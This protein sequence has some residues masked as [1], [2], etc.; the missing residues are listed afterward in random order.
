MDDALA[1]KQG[2][3]LPLFRLSRM[4]RSAALVSIPVSRSPVRNTRTPRS[5][6]R[7]A[8]A[9]RACSSTQGRFEPGSCSM[10]GA[11]PQ[12]AARNR[13]TER[14]F[15][16]S[17]REKSF[18]EISQ[19]RFGRSGPRRSRD[20]HDAHREQYVRKPP[21]LSGRDDEHG[22]RRHHLGIEILFH[23]PGYH[24]GARELW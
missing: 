9:R 21:G 11:T 23:T 5:F 6:W 7:G 12:A 15:G 17:D 14:S 20:G 3:D 2:T 22:I 18:I 19:N 8:A 1:L 24:A 4:R 13:A 16:V 10:E